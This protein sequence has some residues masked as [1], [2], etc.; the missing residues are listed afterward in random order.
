M[1]KLYN[2]H[3][4]VLFDASKPLAESKDKISNYVHIIVVMRR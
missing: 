4:Y 3:N 1:Q 2:K